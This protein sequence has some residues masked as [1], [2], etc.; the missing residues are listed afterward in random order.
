MRMEDLAREVCTSLPNAYRVVRDLQ[1]LNI[2]K[3]QPGRLSVFSI[4]WA[5]VAGLA[6]LKTDEIAPAEILTDDK[7]IIV[8]DKTVIAGDNLILAGD[9]EIIVGENDTTYMNEK[10]ESSTSSNREA[11]VT[12]VRECG[13]NRAVEAVETA[14]RNGMSDEQIRAVVRQFRD[15]ANTGRWSAGVLHDRLTCPGANLLAPD[16]GWFGDSAAWTARQRSQPAPAPHLTRA[17]RLEE[18][19]GAQLDAMSDD[20]LPRLVEFVAEQ[21]KQLVR[22][23]I[24]AG[25]AKHKPAREYVLEAIHRSRATVGVSA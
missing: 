23:A 24:G 9:N 17:A 1:E 15:P 19:Y 13:V 3:R 18:R 7:E 12:A 10:N 16:A 11:A 25:Y 14:R 20:E 22:D 5:R 4:N 2:L 21:T 6:P 8:G